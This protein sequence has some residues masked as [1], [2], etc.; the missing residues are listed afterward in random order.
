MGRTN[1]SV[2]HETFFEKQADI[3]LNLGCG[4]R[5]PAG[6]VNIDRSPSL[7]LARVPGARSLLRRAGVLSKEHM[8]PWPRSIK[9]FDVTKPLPYPNSSVSAIYS[10]H[11]LE[12]LY[13]DQALLLLRECHR[14][15]RPGGMIRLALPDAQ[16]LARRLLSA[17]GDEAAAAG[18]EFTKNLLMGPLS[19]P[20]RRER[21]VTRFSSSSHRWQPTP[22]LVH[23]MLRQ[24]G[25]PN[26]QPREYLVGALPGLAEVEHRPDSLFVEAIR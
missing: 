14:T 11:T 4:L 6:W 20:T 17:A 10:S 8:V 18:L 13:Y 26:P 5:A 15:L 19:R 3:R 7:T 16:V 25:F 24:A 2:T 22:A 9:Q 23:E 1:L 12:H 21:V